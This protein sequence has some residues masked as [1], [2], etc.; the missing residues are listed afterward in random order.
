M[1]K[2]FIADWLTAAKLVPAV[3]LLVFV[4]ELPIWGAFV[5]FALGELL[6]AL[7]GIAAKTW[8]HPKHT[9]GLWFR[10]HIKQLE[11]GLDMLLGIAA[12]VFLSARVSWILGAVMLFVAVLV[13]TVGETVLYGKILGTPQNCKPH[14]LFAR[15]VLLARKIVGLRLY[16]I[17]QWLA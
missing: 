8:P 10:R 17:S 12:L 13:G 11:S 16:F 15:N 1:K 2:Y 7:D 9:D 6:D 5:C 4:T 3:V 14:A